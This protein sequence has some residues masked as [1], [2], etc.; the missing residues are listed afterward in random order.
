VLR[1]ANWGG[2]G[3]DDE[4]QR[5]INKINHDF[6]EA[7]PG[8]TVQVEGIPG[9]YVQKML[10]NHIAGAM[11]DVMVVDASSAAIFIDNGILADLTP[12]FD[13]EPGL[14]EQYWPNVLQV[15]AR[16]SQQFGLPN[17]F[18][19][20]VMYYNKDL[21]DKAGVPYPDEH[22]T[23]EDFRTAAQ[24]LT[25]G[26]QYGFSFTNWMPGWVMWLW[27]NGGDVLSKGSDPKAAGTL[28]S[29]ANVKTIE[30]LRDLIVKDKASP[31]LSQTAALGVDLFANG[32]AAM[33][34][35]GHW[36]LVSYKPSKEIDWKKI[37]VVPLPSNLAW[38][39]RGVHAGS[40]TVLYMS[41]YGIPKEAKHKELA[42]EYVKHWTTYAVQ[43]EYNKSG[44]AVCARKDVA[45]QRAKSPV[46]GPIEASFL[47]IIPRGRPPYGSFIKGYESVEKQGQA[48]MDTILNN[49]DRDIKLELTKAARKIDWEFSKSK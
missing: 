3:Q 25:K 47:P 2:A 29:D 23:F 28:D 14:K 37:G 40:Q 41:A 32:K 38:V 44:I 42:W 36:S 45:E 16:G 48:M 33:T 30:F 7:H 4:F 19:P 31:S 11:P 15:Y 43:S 26:D 17:D 1:I 9:E 22:W 39:S 49:P 35:S 6:E 20:M 12:Y 24:K 5:Q 8:V 10:L 21:F 46:D 13:K 34:V 18:T 27:N